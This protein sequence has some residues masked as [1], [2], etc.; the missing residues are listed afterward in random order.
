MPGGRQVTGIPTAEAAS[1]K[2]K[3][4]ERTMNSLIF[5]LILVASLV[6]C[7]NLKE[8]SSFCSSYDIPDDKRRTK[9]AKTIKDFGDSVQY[10][11]FEC[12]LDKSHLDK[13]A[14]RIDKIIF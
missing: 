5:T 6:S 8:V 4:M 9:L 2:I 1:L 14:D 3:A 7:A 10:S 12:L 11:V 13:M